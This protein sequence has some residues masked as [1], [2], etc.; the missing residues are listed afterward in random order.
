MNNQLKNILVNAA[1]KGI[2]AGIR[3]P[4]SRKIYDFYQW[5]RLVDVLKALRINV[6]LDVG[7]NRGFYSKHLR[8]SGYSGHIFSFE[9][10]ADDYGRLE[11]LSELDSKWKSFCYAL[12]ATTGIRD[13]HLNLFGTETVLSSFLPLTERSDKTQ[14][15]T[16]QIKRLDEVLPSLLTNIDNPRI[17]LKMDTQGFDDEVLEGSK[18]CLNLIL[19]IQ[20]EISVLPLY[21]GMPHYTKSL[22]DYEQLGFQLMDL[23]VVNRAS[24]GG[25]IEYDCLM[26]KGSSLPLV[27]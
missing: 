15:V 4:S 25:I 6:F 5:G 2:A 26:A 8:M 14:V 11:R 23:F 19:G 7:A 18:G 16:V 12:G 1:Y 17:F 22:H 10:I 24:N 21:E 13:F 27:G 9:P 20:S 3:L